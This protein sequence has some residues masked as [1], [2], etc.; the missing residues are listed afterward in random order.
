[1][2][3]YS[4]VC[5]NNHTFEAWFKSSIAFDEQKNLGIV[6]CPICAVSQVSK[7][8]MAPSVGVKSN[9][10]DDSLQSEDAP[11]ITKEPALEKTTNEK[12]DQ[13]LSSG[14]PDQ[15][16]LQAIIR[17]LRKKITSEADY[18]GDKF[19]VE[20]RKIHEHESEARSIYGEATRDE[21]ASLIEDG[22]DILPLPTLP[23][24]QN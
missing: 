8:M 9:R 5:E 22:V 17:K 24:E 16:K 10:Q 21:T 12:P 1:V 23:E 2:I 13:F 15:A 14:H 11:L 6:T 7:A 3:Q 4:L 19:A 18:V 20:A